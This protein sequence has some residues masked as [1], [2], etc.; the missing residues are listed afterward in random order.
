M[1]EPT[2]EIGMT[3]LLGLMVWTDGL[4]T[5]GCGDRVRIRDK[6]GGLHLNNWGDNIIPKIVSIE[7][8]VDIELV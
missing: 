3:N 5:R 7:F 1:V 6:D 4:Q 8:I 2:S